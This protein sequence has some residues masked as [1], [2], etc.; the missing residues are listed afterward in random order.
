MEDFKAKIPFISHL[1]SLSRFETL[2]VH[3]RALHV[4]FWALYRVRIRW[5]VVAKQDLY[6][7]TT[8]DSHLVEVVG[9][10]R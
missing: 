4:F 9:Q 1:S 6:P 5:V 3:R 2:S 10:W 7:V 8:T